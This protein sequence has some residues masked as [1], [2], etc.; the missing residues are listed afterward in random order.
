MPSQNKHTATTESS[1][2]S[3]PAASSTN[4][5]MD[6]ENIPQAKRIKTYEERYD[7]YNRSNEEVL[8]MFFY[9]LI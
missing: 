4:F 3:S 6:N 9:Q 5:S 7:I 2:P 8:G 1:A